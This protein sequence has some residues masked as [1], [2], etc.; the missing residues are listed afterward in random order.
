MDNSHRHRVWILGGPILSQ[1]LDSVILLGPFQLRIFYDFM[2]D[3]LSDEWYL[4][5]LI[6][7]IMLLVAAFIVAVFSCS[8]LGSDCKLCDDGSA[9]VM[10]VYLAQQSPDSYSDSAKSLTGS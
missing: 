5:F 4:P 6:L 9:F 2:K 10:S 8:S 3:C 7:W 1:E